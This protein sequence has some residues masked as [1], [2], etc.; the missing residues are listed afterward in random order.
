MNI[1]ERR[2]ELGLS[3]GALAEKAGVTVMSICRYEN[4]KRIPPLD[5]AV[6]IAKALGCTVDDLLAKE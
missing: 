6:K 4:G 5:I 2:I 1:K 3:Q